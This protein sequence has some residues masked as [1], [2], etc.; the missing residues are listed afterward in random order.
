M[1]ISKILLL[2]CN[3]RLKVFKTTIKSID[4]NIL[5]RNY[6]EIDPRM[7]SEKMTE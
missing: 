5:S 7:Q 4:P 2:F 3:R 1:K 6:D